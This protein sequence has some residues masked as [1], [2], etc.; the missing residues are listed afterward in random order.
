MAIKKGSDKSEKLIGTSKADTISGLSG[1]DTL[2]GGLDN[3]LLEGGL[4]NDSLLGDAGRDTLNGGLGADT[5]QGGN[6]DDFYVVDDLKDSVIETNKLSKTGGVDTVNVLL[7]AYTLPNNVEQIFFENPLAN[8]GVGNAL[9]NTLK[10]HQ[11]NDTLIGNAGNDTLI[12]QKGD[13]L[14][15]GGLGNDLLEGGDGADTAVF[16]G[17]AS[18][19]DIVIEDSLFNGLTVRSIAQ[20]LLNEDTD[21][22]FNIEF[23][24]FADKTIQVSDWLR[25]LQNSSLD[26]NTTPKLPAETS[27]PIP[28][29][30]FEKTAPILYQ[31]SNV[32]SL[33][34][35]TTLLAFEP[36]VT[37]NVSFQTTEPQQ[38]RNRASSEELAIDLT[39]TNNVTHQVILQGTLQASENAQTWYK[40]QLTKT[41][42]LNLQDLSPYANVIDIA[43]FKSNSLKGVGYFNSLFD[44]SGQLKQYKNLP[45]GDYVLCIDKGDARQTEPRLKQA[46]DFKILVNTEPSDDFIL[47][48]L[49]VN[50][51]TST[52]HASLQANQSDI[53]YKF[54]IDSKTEVTIDNAK[55]AQNFEISFCIPTEDGYQGV[56]YSYYDNKPQQHIYDLASGSYYLKVLAKNKLS[57][58]TDIIIPFSSADQTIPFKTFLSVAPNTLKADTQ[59]AK[60]P[61]AYDKDG[62][63]EL[64]YSFDL[65]KIPKSADA[66]SNAVPFSDIQ[67]QATRL[68][69]EEYS[70]IAKLTFREIQKNSA[71]K[72]NITFT[73]VS[74]LGDAAGDTK[75]LLSLTNDTLSA[76]VRFSLSA[77]ENANLS[78]G[79]EGYHTLLHEIGHALGLKH[80]S[81]YGEGGA[82][83][84]VPFLIG[85]KDNQQYSVMSYNV[86]P[87]KD[88][89]E[90]FKFYENTGAVSAKTPLL[91]DIAAIQLLYG[92]NQ[93]YN[94]SNTV[95]HWDQNADP[96][97]CIW[98][99][100]GVDTID[101][102]NQTQNQIIDLRAG[103]FSSLG[104]VKLQY[105]DGSIEQYPAKDNVSIA[106]GTLIENAIGSDKDDTLIG[107]SLANQLTGNKGRDYFVFASPL[108]EINIDTITDFNSNDDKLMFDY[109]IFNGLNATEQV[110]S[111]EFLAGLHL[112]NAENPWQRLI[113]DTF[114]HYLYYDSDGSGESNPMPI[115]ILPNVSLLNVENLLILS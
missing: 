44:S 103:E 64:T 9:D 73:N 35:I 23:L 91:Y 57:Q 39:Q 108:S 27:K 61:L 34:S 33:D 30:N 31:A 65:A 53:F 111:R 36:V 4:G 94:T 41:G 104:A 98:D 102:N 109:S 90:Q 14:L 24:K 32:R 93:A 20:G 28:L 115:A 83:S 52:I 80:P 22:L 19:Y 99:A 60:F 13:D 17:N 114:S 78:Q 106:Y 11:S 67:Q 55:L 8:K 82:S 86:H 85:S 3:D 79:G 49:V 38:W 45:A 54:T 16:K 77:T 89:V 81:S 62:N 69:L 105:R 21:L 37:N 56:Q 75:Q 50:A 110:T 88:D 107:N 112:K 6:G 7:S 63:L 58:P 70:H 101:V 26:S 87:Y 92:A 42:T 1:Q 48:D 18:E 59:Q 46:I 68:V 97:M 84:D 29:A 10:G 12:A 25:E 76:T 95:Y 51:N 96:F 71:E 43:L 74:T 100:G 40:I 2:L 72:A 47:P 5:M 113:F 66:L 15:E